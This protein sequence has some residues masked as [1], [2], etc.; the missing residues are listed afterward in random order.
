ML[1]GEV[2]RLGELGVIC[3]GQGGSDDIRVHLCLVLSLKEAVAQ[4]TLHPVD[5][6]ED[7]CRRT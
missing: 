7:C 1:D 2:D 3:F 5:G 4:E 6:H